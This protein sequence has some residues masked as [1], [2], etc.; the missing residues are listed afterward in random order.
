MRPES[1]IREH[2]GSVSQLEFEDCDNCSARIAIGGS[3]RTDV[4]SLPVCIA[5]PRYQQPDDIEKPLLALAS[6]GEGCEDLS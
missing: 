6:S 1:G 3:C 5:M 2:C 4:S